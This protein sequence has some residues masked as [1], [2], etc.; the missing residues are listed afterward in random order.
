MDDYGESA[1][2]DIPTGVSALELADSELELANSNANSNA[3]SAKVG[4]WVR[5]LI[6]YRP[7]SLFEQC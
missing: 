2:D 6:H 1:D 3:D 7:D 5:A 4:V